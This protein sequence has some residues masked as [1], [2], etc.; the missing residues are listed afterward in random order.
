MYVSHIILEAEDGAEVNILTNSATSNVLEFIAGS[1][2]TL[3]G[4]TVGHNVEKG[5]CTGNVLSF[6]ACS[7]VSPLSTLPPGNS[8]D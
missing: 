1:D 3:K 2:I 5:D 4:L 6:N 7:G 8:R